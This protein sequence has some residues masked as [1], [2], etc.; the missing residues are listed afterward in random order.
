MEKAVAPITY[1]QKDLDRMF[2][3]LLVAGLV[4]F[5][6]VTVPPGARRARSLRQDAERAQRA[7]TELERTHETLSL[8]ERALQS[9]PFYNEL[10]LRTGMKYTRPGEKEIQTTLPGSSAAVAAD[11]PV[12]PFVPSPAAGPGMAAQ[13]T[14]WALLAASAVMVAAAFILFDRPSPVGQTQA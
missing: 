1:R 2:W 6:I 14:N 5:A 9:D 13:V 10:V 7:V 8:R 11:A 4:F 12:D 3:L